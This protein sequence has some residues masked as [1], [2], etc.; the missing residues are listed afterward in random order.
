MPPLVSALMVTQ[1]GRERF[2]REAVECFHAQTYPNK[3][4]V[5]VVQPYHEPP[6]LGALRNESV[7]RAKGEYVIQWDDDDLYGPER[8]QSHVDVIHPD[9]AASCRSQLVLRCICGHEALSQARHWE[10]TIMVRRDLALLLPYEKDRTMGEDSKFV[11]D[12][13][14]R[15]WS[16]RVADPYR[17]VYRMHSS[18]T[19]KPAHWDNLFQ[20]GD[21]PR[22]HPS[23]CYSNV[24][25]AP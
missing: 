19:C 8:I 24:S 15:G 6:K 9:V 17:Y 3:E 16:I 7:L 13:L 18:N 5:I 1:S 21:D 20:M 12:I 22:H 4:L 11:S 14:T 10:Q 2:A 25:Q 23:T